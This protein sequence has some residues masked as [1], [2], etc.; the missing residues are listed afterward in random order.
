[1]IP[2]LVRQVVENAKQRELENK[3]Q[4]LSLA[5]WQVEVILMGLMLHGLDT[6]H[7]VYNWSRGLQNYKNKYLLVLLVVRSEAEQTI[8]L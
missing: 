1:M 5:R 4:I 7:H 3:V 2:I 6:T 8:L